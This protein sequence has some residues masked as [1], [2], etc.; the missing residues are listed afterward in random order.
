MSTD[1]FN[2]HGPL[3]EE[4]L[5][6]IEKI[7][8]ENQN[9]E[10][11]TAMEEIVETQRYIGEEMGLAT[12]NV[13]LGELKKVLE[14]YPESE[15]KTEISEV[16][17]SANECLSASFDFFSA[18]EEDCAEKYKIWQT[19][20]KYYRRINQ[21]TKEMLSLKI[22][23]LRR[24]AEGEIRMP[25]IVETAYNDRQ[26]ETARQAEVARLAVEEA[27]RAQE[28]IQRVQR[29]AEE[30]AERVRQEAETRERLR[31]EA[32]ERVR[33][34]ESQATARAE[35]DIRRRAAE[36]AVEFQ[37]N[38]A[39]VRRL[40]LERL[41]LAGNVKADILMEM[42]I[43][44]R[45]DINTPEGRKKFVEAWR[46][47]CADI[48]MPCVPDRNGDWSK[49]DYWF[50]KQLKEGRIVSN[51]SG[52]AKKVLPNY[53]Q[54]EILLMDSWQEC[55]WN[56]S[57]AAVKHRSTLLGE[58]LGEDGSDHKRSVVNIKRKDIDDA[59]WQGDPALRI[60]SAKQ[61]EIIIKLGLNPADFVFS[62][63]DQGAYARGAVSQGWGQKNLWTNFDHYF[64]EVDG[65]RSGLLGGYRDG[66]GPSFVGC[67]WRV[68]SHASLAVRLVLSRK[69]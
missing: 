5:G 52:N 29:E 40:G 18:P 35:A 12:D 24:Q 8:Q 39:E 19:A 16:I 20:I 23:W 42:N 56:A 55:D 37:C 25:E 47:D 61:K 63:M 15:I 57:D 26:I 46:T 9:T 21:F 14:T 45:I 65:V 54:H 27:R 68:S 67:D 50:L 36:I 53:G 10:V 43:S 58:L 11:R 66:G 44:G 2:S 49:G 4:D 32:E 6:A 62:L 28:E 69:Q 33:Q 48:P 17:E 7:R 60:P 38:E 31:I 64:L 3:S 30:A 22:K 41:D 1:H 34:E 59:L 13:M 51:L